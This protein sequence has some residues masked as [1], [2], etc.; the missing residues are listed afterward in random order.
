[1]QPIKKKTTPQDSLFRDRLENILN[2]RHEL[3]QLAG[4]IDWSVFEKEFGKLYSVKKGRPGI[5]IRLMVGLA[6]L[7]HAYGLSDEAV[8]E[9]RESA[10]A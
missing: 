3:Y 6:Y 10:R 9:P 4:L 2:R 5:P 8:V 7:G 1:M